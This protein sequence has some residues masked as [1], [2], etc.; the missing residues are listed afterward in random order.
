M[1]ALNVT[2]QFAVTAPVVNVLVPVSKLPPQVLEADQL[3]PVAG[4]AVNVVV[5]P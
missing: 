5:V 1:V 2:V 4:V 3:Y